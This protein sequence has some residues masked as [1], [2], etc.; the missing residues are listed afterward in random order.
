LPSISLEANLLFVNVLKCLFYFIPYDV[1]FINSEDSESGDLI[2]ASFIG[3]QVEE[4]TGGFFVFEDG[5]VVF[6]LKFS[7]Q[8]LV[9]DSRKLDF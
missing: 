3:L 2:V 1:L 5:K 7:S 8:V 9:L 4:V 6:I